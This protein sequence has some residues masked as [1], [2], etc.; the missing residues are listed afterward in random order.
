MVGAYCAPKLGTPGDEDDRQVRP[1]RQSH[2]SQSDSIHLGHA[3]VGDQ[4][5]DVGEAATFPALSCRRVPANIV[6]GRSAAIAS[7]M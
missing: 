5:I 1:L 4:A 3:D 7:R 2:S 6:A